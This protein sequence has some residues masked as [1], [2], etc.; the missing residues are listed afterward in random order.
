VGASVNNLLVGRSI[1]ALG[2]PALMLALGSA[3]AFAS[4]QDSGEGKKA[5]KVSVTVCKEV[6]KKK[7]K[8]RGGKDD[9]EK[10]K[11]SFV[12][13]TDLAKKS[14]DLKDGQCK[15]NLKLK[16]DKAKVTVSEEKVRGYKVK[17]I[18]VWGDVK[19]TTEPPKDDNKIVI[20]FKDKDEAQVGV[21]F[22]NQKKDH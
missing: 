22:V 15:H 16:F 6:D 3:P 7:D 10:Q 21:K 12:V 14:F 18:I 4:A 20:K 8:S 2:V 1:A 17:D 9:D 5:D 11:F 19:K 13:E